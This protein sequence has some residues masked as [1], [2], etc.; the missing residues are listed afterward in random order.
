MAY[1]AGGARFS[2]F[3]RLAGILYKKM[4]KTGNIP[5][6]N[7]NWREGKQYSRWLVLVE[8]GRLGLTDS[9]PRLP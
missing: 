3:P 6:V 4:E 1:R 2:I 9:G 8:G 7:K 5:S